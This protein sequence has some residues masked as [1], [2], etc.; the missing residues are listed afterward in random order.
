MIYIIRN[1]DVYSSRRTSEKYFIHE[2]DELIDWL[3]NQLIDES[4]K[5]NILIMTKILTNLKI[6]KNNNIIIIN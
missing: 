4:I 6:F 2:N 1:Q 3:I 5:I